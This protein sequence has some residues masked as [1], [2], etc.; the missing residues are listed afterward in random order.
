[1]FTP[2][3][4]TESGKNVSA[5]RLRQILPP[6]REKMSRLFA[7]AKYCRRIGK[8]CLGFSLTP[9]IAAQIDFRVTPKTAIYSYSEHSQWSPNIRS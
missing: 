5:F 7:Y 1:M 4:A 8:K 9:N 2:N 3:I 6:N